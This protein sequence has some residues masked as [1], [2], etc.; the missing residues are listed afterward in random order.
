MLKFKNIIIFIVVGVALVF[1]YIYFIRPSPEQPGLVSTASTTDATTTS[2]MSNDDALGTKDFL[3]ILLNVK[4]VKLDD[5]IF[6]NIAF[7]N[8]HD[9]S[10]VLTADGNEGRPNPFAPI[11]V[12]ATAAQTATTINLNTT[13]APSAPTTPTAPGKTN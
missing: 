13:Q 4:N 12:D 2:S 8:L 1:V 11:G 9:S 3:T 5:A 6:S 7:Q 10:I